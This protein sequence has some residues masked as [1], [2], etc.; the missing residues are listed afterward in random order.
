MNGIYC[1]IIEGK[2]VFS[3]PEERVEEFKAA[4][5]NSMNPDAAQLVKEIAK[6]RREVARLRK[7]YSTELKINKGW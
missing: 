6:L 5:Y 7:R 2:L 1:Y 3:V 4:H